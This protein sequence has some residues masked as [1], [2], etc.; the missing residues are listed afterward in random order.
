MFLTFM[1]KWWFSFV[2][3]M[4]NVMGLF[5]IMP[6]WLVCV[7]KRC[8]QLVISIFSFLHMSV[9][10]ILVIVLKCAYCI[11]RNMI[12]GAKGIWNYIMN[13]EKIGRDFIGTRVSLTNLLGIM[14]TMSLLKMMMKISLLTGLPPSFFSFPALFIIAFLEEYKS[15]LMSCAWACRLTAFEIFMP[16][17]GTESQLYFQYFEELF[18]IISVL[19]W[20]WI[21]CSKFCA[22]VNY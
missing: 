14:R 1:I 9:N 11:E 3:W 5:M 13:F 19:P 12:L 20:C 21:F 6:Y 22:C 8:C 7:G 2:M 4:R 10:W 18:F 16:K 15:F 17:K